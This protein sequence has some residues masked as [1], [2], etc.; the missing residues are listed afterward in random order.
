MQK[1]SDNYGCG[2][3]AVANALAL[4][5]FVTSER[6]ELSKEGDVIGRLSKY[7]Q[8][9]GHDACIDV[10][11]YD[12]VGHSIPTRYFDYSVEKCIASP[13]LFNVKLS[14]KGRRHLIAGHLFPDGRLVVCDSLREEPFTTT[15]SELHRHYN[16]VFGFFVFMNLKGDYLFFN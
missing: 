6:L 7:L 11:Y 8:D 9:D 13:F 12:H 3:Y 14:E 16:A 5:N 1:Q 15:L 10:I 4:D 2:L